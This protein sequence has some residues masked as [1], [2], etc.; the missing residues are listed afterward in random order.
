MGFHLRLLFLLLCPL[1]YLLWTWGMP[2]ILYCAVYKL[3]VYLLEKREKG[4]LR[5]RMLLSRSCNEPSF[6]PLHS[7]QLHAIVIKRSVIS[8]L[9]EFRRY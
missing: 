5:F 6:S 8:I 2:H 4:K 3:F 9:P 7:I 1:C